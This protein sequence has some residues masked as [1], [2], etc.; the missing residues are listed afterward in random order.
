MAPPHRVFLSRFDE[1]TLGLTL[2]DG[3]AWA[4]WEEAFEI[5]APVFVKPNLT[6][7]SY[8]PGVTTSPA[9]IEAVLAAVRE[10]TRNI[11]VGESDG[12]FRCWPAEMAFQT[13]D[14]ERICRRFDARLVNLSKLPTETVQWRS[15]DRTAPLDLPTLLT[16]DIQA[17]VTLPVPKI[18]VITRFS[19]AVKNQWGCIPNNMRLRYHPYFDDGILEL[20]RIVKTRLAIMDGMFML[21]HSGPMFGNAVRADTLI[22]ARDIR[23]ADAVA[24][25][26]MR[27]EALRVKHLN[28][29]GALDQLAV[30]VNVVPEA[31]SRY[32]FT[33]H[34]TLRNWL[35]VFA[36]S[37]PWATWLLWDSRLGDWLHRVL[38]A[39][40]PN[41]VR[42]EIEALRACLRRAANHERPPVG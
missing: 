23:A 3:L 27:I 37:R 18:H 8:K 19:G 33:L 16:R 25:R 26:F 24:C 22:V 36:F 14:L 31:L 39:I 42:D 30:N 35:V 2:R 34:R 9:M 17:L 28:T 6:Y 11:W 7:P 5:D 12:G 15:G 10:R 20:N 38:Y 41:P 21:D 4:N 29:E 1:T 40:R 32:G 13:H